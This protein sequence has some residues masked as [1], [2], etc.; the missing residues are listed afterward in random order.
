MALLRKLPRGSFRKRHFTHTY[1]TANAYSG[2]RSARTG[3]LGAASNIYSYSSFRQGVAIPANATRVTLYFSLWQWTTEAPS[4]PIPKRADMDR[5]NAVMSGD[6]QYVLVLNPNNQAIDTLYWNRKNTQ[7]WTSL[8]V[9]M[10]KYK[11]QTLELHFGTFN[12]GA[13]GYTGMYV[14]DVVMF[15]QPLP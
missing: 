3:A 5:P 15:A 12:D 14:D 1:A 13:G 6:V 10:T 4:V 11:G 8:T 7:Q 9:D 2:Y